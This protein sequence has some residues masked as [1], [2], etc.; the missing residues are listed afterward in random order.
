MK[1]LTGWLPAACAVLGAAL[2][3][4][5]A[6]QAPPPW[7]LPPEVRTLT[8]N[9]YPMAYTSKGSGPAVVLVH[10]ALSDYRYW[11]PQLDSLSTRYRVVSVSLRHYFPE[12]WKGSGDDFSVRQHAEDL[13]AFIDRLGAGPVHLVAHSRGGSVGAGAAR[14]RPD[15]VKKL[16]LLEPSLLSLAP[17][18]ATAGPDPN[19][20]RART[21]GDLLKKGDTEAALEYYIDDLNGRGAWKARTEESRQRTRDNAWTVIGG[22][23][24]ADIVGCDELRAMPMP[25]LLV[26]SEKG[27]AVLRRLLGEAQKCAPAARR[28]LIPAAGHTMNRDNPAA[29]DAALSAFLEEAP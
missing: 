24:H 6:T 4:A 19:I 27:P 10:G 1:R 28:V 26:E 3:A 18:A 12:R 16:V 7:E 11:R 14:L 23:R 13:V 9:G 5:C 15:L 22:A 29:F 17:P 21:T 25:I 20:V 2:L 8:V